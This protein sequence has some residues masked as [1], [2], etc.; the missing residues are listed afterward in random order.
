MKTNGNN[1]TDELTIS[2]IVLVV[3]QLFRLLFGGYLIGLDQFHYNDPESAISVFLI[4]A[5]VGILTAL[6]LIGKRKIGLLGLMALSIML[7]I[8]ESAYVIVYV[9]QT[10]PDPS[11]H[12][13]FAIWWATVSNFLF[14]L[15]T[16]IYAFKVYKEDN[17]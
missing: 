12:S 9:S 4:Y 7:L 8:M 11:W 2:A 14:P 6:F 16:L 5:V 17:I 3:I 15:L 10:T 1:R 13:P